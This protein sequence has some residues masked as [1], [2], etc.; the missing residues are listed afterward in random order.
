MEW[1]ETKQVGNEQYSNSYDLVYCL[2]HQLKE[3][4]VEVWNGNIC[5]VYYAKTPKEAFMMYRNIRLLHQKEIPLYL[6]RHFMK[7]P[8]DRNE[9][10]REKIDDVVDF[11]AMSFNWLWW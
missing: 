10:I 4:K 1:S 11:F 9:F 8:Q 7:I 6:S 5:Y 3:K 2:K